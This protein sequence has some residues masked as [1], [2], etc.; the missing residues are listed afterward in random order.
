M[1]I[2][3][4][5]SLN[6]KPHY[7]SHVQHLFTDKNLCPL[8]LS[9]TIDTHYSCVPFSQYENLVLILMICLQ[10]YMIKALYVKWYELFYLIIVIRLH[11][12]VVTK[13]ITRWSRFVTKSLMKV[14]FQC[15]AKDVIWNYLYAMLLVLLYVA[16]V[17]RR[18]KA[19][20]F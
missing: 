7:N 2:F 19:A 4:I 10:N 17:S 13:R 12:S 15:Y 6:L 5:S 1:C 16:L 9:C 20:L 8:V 11:L 3:M 14:F 18:I